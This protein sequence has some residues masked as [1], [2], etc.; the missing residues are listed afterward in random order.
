MIARTILST[1]IRYSHDVNSELLGVCERLSPEQ[2]DA[3]NSLGLGSLHETAFHVIRVEEEWFELCRTG[4]PQFGLR[5]LEQFPDIAS[6]RQ[7]SD[8]M[9]ARIDAWFSTATDDDLG[10]GVT[11]LLPHGAV[12]TW[13]RWRI[14][15]HAFTHSTL[16]RGEMAALLTGFGHSPGSIDFYGYGAAR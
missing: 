14:F 10:A 5:A 3:P 2:W 7:L 1:M 16:H 6:L 8:D 15:V 4:T 12:A 13:P 9:C 11:A